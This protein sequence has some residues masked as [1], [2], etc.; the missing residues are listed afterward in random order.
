MK[1]PFDR[2]KQKNFQRFCGKLIFCGT[3]KAMQ[4]AAYPC[5]AIPL[6]FIQVVPD[7]VVMILIGNNANCRRHSFFAVQTILF[8]STK[9]VHHIHV[10]QCRARTLP[11]HR[12]YNINA[13]TQQIQPDGICKN[14]VVLQNGHTV[15]NRVLNTT[16]F[17]LREHLRMLEMVDLVFSDSLGNL[18]NLLPMFG[19]KMS[20]L[21]QILDVISIMQAGNKAGMQFFLC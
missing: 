10:G 9:N 6:Q 15:L 2:S 4:G 3:E 18:L 7:G 14:R 12:L 5:C 13:F 11:A 1:H 20:I 21:Y 16:F 19:E 8:H 17:S